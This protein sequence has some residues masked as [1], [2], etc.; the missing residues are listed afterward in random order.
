DKDF[1]VSDVDVAIAIIML[2]DRQPQE[3]V[4]LFGAVTTKSLMMTNLIDSPLHRIDCRAW[5]W[6]GDIPN[7]ASNQSLGCFRIGFAKF[8]DSLGDLRKKIAGLKFKIM[9]V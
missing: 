7:S 9:F 4:T 6:L 5:Q 1:V 3:F 2:G 8:P